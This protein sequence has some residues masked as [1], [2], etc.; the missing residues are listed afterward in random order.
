MHRRALI[1]I[2]VSLSCSVGWANGWLDNSGF[3]KSGDLMAGPGLQLISEDLDL[4]LRGDGFETEALYHVRADEGGYQ[5]ELLFPVLCS[6]NQC[7][8]HF[9]AFV[10]DKEAE[11][12]YATPDEALA[13]FEA[14][15]A[16]AV[17]DLE[18]VIDARWLEAMAD[19]IFGRQLER[20]A[21]GNLAMPFGGLKVFRILP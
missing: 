1:G 2:I 19:M 5:G 15:Y 12:T 3:I 9:E 20:D 7:V 6:G 16:R 13:E 8:K 4:R 11:V 10:A 14:R 18:T 21:D 17:Y